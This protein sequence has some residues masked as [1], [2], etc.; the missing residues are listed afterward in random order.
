MKKSILT[1]S[2]AAALGGLGFAGT[3]QA[4]AYFGNGVGLTANANEVSLTPGAVGHL[5][6]TPY[7][8]T[9]GTNGTL[10]NITNTDGKNG[11]AVKVR[12]RGA[13][14]S[15][16]VLDFT[17]FLSPGDVW[18]ASV[19]NDA[20]GRASISTDDKSCTIPDHSAWP[21]SFSDLRLPSYI[22]AAAKKFEQVD[23]R[24]R[25]IQRR[26]RTVQELPAPEDARTALGLTPA[27]SDGEEA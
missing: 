11:K 3:A 15:D 9:Q 25:A 23:V 14:N 24:T 19:T 6:V 21:A 8:S 7:Y 27:P 13:A 16:D 2:A 4:V 20:S 26:L 12:F 5:L 1:L 17:V 22:D 18:T 10:F